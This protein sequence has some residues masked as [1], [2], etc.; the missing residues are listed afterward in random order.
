LGAACHCPDLWEC[1]Q[2]LFV[3]DRVLW[4][5]RLRYPEDISLACILVVPIENINENI[6]VKYITTQCEFLAGY[7]TSGNKSV[8]VTR[9]DNCLKA[10]YATKVQI[11]GQNPCN[12]HE[13]EFAEDGLCCE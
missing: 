10:K 6:P 3:Q 2:Q 4:L 12:S 8:G 9:E 7:S 5:L 13:H 1:P 11:T